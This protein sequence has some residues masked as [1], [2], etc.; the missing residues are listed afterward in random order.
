VSILPS[1]RFTGCDGGES[2]LVTT[3]TER[4][5]ASDTVLTGAVDLARAAAE[6]LAEPGHVG[7]HQGSEADG[8]RLVTHYFACLNPAYRGWRWAVTVTR[9]SR[10]KT[11]T[12]AEAVLLPGSDALLAPAWV[13]WSERLKPGDLGVGDLLPTRADDERLLP[14]YT[15]SID[16]DADQIAL[17]ELGLGRPRVLSPIGRDDAVDRWY[18]GDHGPTA[19]IAEAA[20]AACATCGFLTLMAG[21]M[22]RLFGV[23][24]NE[25]S[26][27]DGRVVSFDHGCGAHS[28]VAVIPGPVDAADPVV[29]EIGFDLLAM[30]SLDYPLGA[31]DE[32]LS[33]GDDA[34]SSVD[35]A[36]PVEDLDN[37]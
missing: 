24:T 22:R 1:V 35:D 14:G 10:S 3:K 33:S 27:S 26:P 8:E 34:L 30:D 4:R 32:T 20:P 7:E 5:P 6:E 25:Y 13:P 28:E 18:S 16:E 37:S 12:V 17:W 21:T 2:A 23:C 36:V 11:V 19:P 29:D 31:V 9:V 15:S